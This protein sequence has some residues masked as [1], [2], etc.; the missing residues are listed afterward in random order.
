MFLNA[1]AAISIALELGIDINLI[2]KVLKNYSGVRRRF[3]LKYEIPNGIKIIDDYAHHPVEVK[4]TINAAKSGW[5]NRVV[6]I[7]QPHSI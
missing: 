5:K 4:A 1:L 3:E 2:K 6:S 7:F